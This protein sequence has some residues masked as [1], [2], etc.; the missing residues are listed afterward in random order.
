MLDVIRQA[1]IPYHHRSLKQTRTP[2]QFIERVVSVEV[3]ADRPVAGR[4]PIRYVFDVEGVG[5]WECTVKV[6]VPKDLSA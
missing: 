6:H 5:R 3:L 4:L 1:S 2:L